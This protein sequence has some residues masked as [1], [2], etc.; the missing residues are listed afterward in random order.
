MPQGW[1]GMGET[2]NS[3]L[4]GSGYK[5]VW[6]IIAS[7]DATTVTFDAPPGVTGVPPLPLMLGKGQVKQFVTS[8]GSSSPGQFFASAEKAIL[9]AGG[10]AVRCVNKATVGCK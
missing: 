8:G 7:E 1:K 3:L 10:M 6:R 9:V 5:S 2:C 4:P